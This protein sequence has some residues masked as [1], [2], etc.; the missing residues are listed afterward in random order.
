ML[1]AALSSPRRPLPLSNHPIRLRPPQVKSA[2]LIL[3]LL[4]LCNY[5]WAGGAPSA[6]A[7]G[8]HVVSPANHS[9]LSA[10]PVEIKLYFPIGPR[11]EQFSAELNGVDVTRRFGSW[12]HQ[13]RRAR[14]FRRHL[15]LGHNSFTAH[16]GSAVANVSFTVE[17]G[18][19]LPGSPQS[20]PNYVPI[21]TRIVSG[22]GSQISDY[23]VQVGGTTYFAPATTY[24]GK[25]TTGGNGFQVLVLD[26]ATLN[27][28]SNTSFG[29]VDNASVVLLS[30]V[31][32]QPQNYSGCGEFGCL[33]IV[34]S[35]SGIGAAGDGGSAFLRIGSLGGLVGFP[36]ASSYSLIT[37]LTPSARP[38][39]EQDM[40]ASATLI[41]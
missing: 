4:G 16:F 17:Q 29:A 23:G 6:S 14:F 3:F 31:L 40:N 32:A 27:M 13:F 19:G 36:A 18:S 33:I 34:Q 11:A 24:Q 39:K 26:R 38:L 15:K 28:V 37:S 35:F 10:L 21:Q 9:K 30:A 7:M 22:D 1:H 12:R 25:P 41:L 8:F 20:Q 5:G 2:I